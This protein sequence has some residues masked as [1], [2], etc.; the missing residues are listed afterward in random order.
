VQQLCK[1][2][3]AGS[4]RNMHLGCSYCHYMNDG[5]HDDFTWLLPDESSD[6]LACHGHS[7]GWTHP[8]GSDC[9]GDCGAEVAAVW[10]TF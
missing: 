7:K 2:C 8:P 4:V 9:H 1:A 6:C 3:H 10:P 5:D